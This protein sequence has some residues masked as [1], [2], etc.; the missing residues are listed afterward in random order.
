MLTLVTGAH[1]FIG[2]HVARRLAAQG[3]RVIGIGHG[4]WDAAAA[5]GVEWVEGEVDLP[6]LAAHGEELALL[7]HCAGSGS[8]PASF[9]DPAADFARTVDTTL[10][11]VEFVRRH[12]PNARLVLP[13]SAAVYGRAERMP[14]A[15]DAPLAPLSPYGV[16]K[17]IAEELVRSHARHFGVRAAIVRLFSI[18]GVGLRKQLLWDAC[19][20][21][22]AGDA[23]FGGDGGETRDWL[24]VEDAAALLI[25]AGNL[26][27]ADCP[28]VNGGMGEGVPI[29]AVV[30]PLAALLAA[31]APV[32]SGEAR[33][34]DP[35][36]FVADVSGAR[37][38]DWRPE[39]DLATELAAYAAWFR[40]GASD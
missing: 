10:A 1:G 36:D 29:R 35:R 22:S 28:A 19:R 2:R 20:K 37:A 23:T 6:T 9:A 39:R 12:A 27:S 21:L 26:A 14:I 31:P 16:H 24:H 11:V 5:W 34:G 4:R 7:V 40:S 25:A 13:S 17:R 33:A 38:L 18:Y 8:V 3:D 30:E 32:F 15:V